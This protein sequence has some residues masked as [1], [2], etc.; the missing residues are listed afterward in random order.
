M[1][2][3]EPTIRSRELGEGLRRAMEYA[4]FNQSTLARELEWSPGRVSRLLAGKRGGSVAEVSNFLATCGIRGK[5][6]D[7]LMALCTDNDRP[8]WLQQHGAYLPKQ[9]RTLMDHE[10]N[11]TVIRDFA[12][13]LV[14]GLLQTADYARAVMQASA[15]LPHGEVE[16]RVSARLA[17]QS[18]LSRSRPPKFKF[19]IHEL[20][21]HTPVAN[22]AVMSDQLHE[23]LRVGVRPNLEVR[24]VPIAAGAHAGMSGS[25]TLLD[26]SG[27]KPIVYLDSETSSLFLETPIEIDAYRKIL[28]SLEDTALDEGQS[29]EMVASLATKIYAD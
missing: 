17:R 22:A 29:R 4:G 11:A 25:F 27:F 7:R 23:L 14:P 19:F 13:I 8:G 12:M 9:L 26:V 1:R 28:A 10:K 20:V 15:N 2:D 24:I 5:E 18:L 21:L 3:R 16:D 6:Y